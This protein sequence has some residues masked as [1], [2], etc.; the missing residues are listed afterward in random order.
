MKCHQNVYIGVLIPHTNY[1]LIDFSE[2]NGIETIN[3]SLQIDD[4]TA[5]A[6]RQLS[7]N[8]PNTKLAKRGNCTFL[9][10][11]KQETNFMA[12]WAK[13]RP[14]KSVSLLVLVT[15]NINN[16]LLIIMRYLF[17][18]SHSPRSHIS[19]GICVLIVIIQSFKCSLILMPP[20]LTYQLSSS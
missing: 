1:K 10:I 13:K 3:N 4:L 18:L 19:F 16:G 17:T 11:C 20:T 6:Q 15:C 12:D 8:H 2:N 7:R 14:T 9:I 5:Q